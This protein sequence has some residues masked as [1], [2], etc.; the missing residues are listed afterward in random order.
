MFCNSLQVKV[1]H[2]PDVVSTSG[3]FRNLGVHVLGVLIIRALPFCVCIRAPDFQNSQEG[4]YHELSHT[5]K[6]DSST[7]GA[8]TMT[9]IMVLCSNYGSNTIKN[10]KCTLE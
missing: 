8:A 3:C 1:C 2:D 4:I 9:N 7:I 10:L 5:D 6:S